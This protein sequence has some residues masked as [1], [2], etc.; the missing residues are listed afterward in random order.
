MS[1]MLRRFGQDLRGTRRTLIV[2]A[3]VFLIVAVTGAAISYLRD[4]PEATGSRDA[5]SSLSRSGLDGEMLAR[6][7][8]YARSTSTEDHAPVPGPGKRL[9]DVNTMIERLAARL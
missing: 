1:L 5:M 8:D 6:L 4:P 2:P 7:K 9:P 3:A